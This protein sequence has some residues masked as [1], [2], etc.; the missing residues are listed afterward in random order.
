MEERGKG[1]TQ[2][3]TSCAAGPREC[4]H[5]LLREGGS[6]GGSLGTGVRTDS[7]MSGRQPLEIVE[8]LGDLRDG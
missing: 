5:G 6:W 2:V 7:G 8:A 4:Q 3:N 1:E